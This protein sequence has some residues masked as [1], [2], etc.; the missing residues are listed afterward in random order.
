MTASS[1]GRKKVLWSSLRVIRFSCR[2]SRTPVPGW[3]HGFLS[4]RIEQGVRGRSAGDLK[5]DPPWY[6][7][8][9]NRRKEENGQDFRQSGPADFRYQR[10][11][12][13][14]GKT[15]VI[16]ETG[17]G[18]LR[19]ANQEGRHQEMSF[20]TD[21]HMHI[22]PGIDD[23]SGSMEESLEEIRM[24]VAQGDLSRMMSETFLRK[25]LE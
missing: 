14:N 16:K 22:I 17:N 12:S 15:V 8:C 24:A 7:A 9:V 5:S 18:Y 21:V 25:Q 23:G 19:E 13:A 20:M 6:N 4:Y 1:T 2:N 3:D 11:I 10:V